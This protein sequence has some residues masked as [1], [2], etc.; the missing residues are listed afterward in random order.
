MFNNWANTLRGFEGS[1]LWVL[2]VNPFAVQNLKKEIQ[3]RGIDSQRLLFADRMNLPIHLV[4]HRAA[5]LF[6]Y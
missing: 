2:A 1:V 5:D 4:R 6:I 3:A